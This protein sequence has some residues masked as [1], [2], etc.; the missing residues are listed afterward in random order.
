MGISVVVSLVL[1]ILVLAMLVLSIVIAVKIYGAK[2]E[3]G[4]ILKD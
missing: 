3:T 1:V 2:R 4:E